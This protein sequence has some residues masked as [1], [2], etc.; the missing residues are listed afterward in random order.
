MARTVRSQ[1]EP[2]RPAGPDWLLVGWLGVVVIRSD[3]RALKP[4]FP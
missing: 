1:H 4:Y 3:I 2:A